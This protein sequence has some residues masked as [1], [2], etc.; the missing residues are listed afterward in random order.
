MSAQAAATLHTHDAAGTARIAVALGTL[1]CDSATESPAERAAPEST[2]SA[3]L[4][5]LCGPLGAGKT[6]FV[7]GLA[8]GLRVPPDEQVASPTFVLVREYRGARRLWHLDA[9]RSGSLEELFDVGLEEML[10]ER[11]AIVAVEWADPF[12]PLTAQ[13][14][15]IAELDYGQAGDDRII[16]LHGPPLLLSRL[17]EQLRA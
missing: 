13:A 9:Y 1:L 15:W 10:S 3:T 14:T 8:A 2:P 12:P 7:R 16:H 11:E 5:A 6:E 4:I 17:L